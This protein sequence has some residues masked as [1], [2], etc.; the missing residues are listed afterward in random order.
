MKRAFVGKWKKPLLW[1]AGIAV[2]VVVLKLTLLAPPQVKGV[3]PAARDLVA[4][5]YGNGTVEAKV[6]VA[7]APKINGR[8]VALF[9]DQGD[10]VRRGQLLARLDNREFSEQVRQSEAM[11][12]RARATGN[13]EKANLEKARATLA[14]AERNAQRYRSLAEKNLVSRQEAEQYETAC[15]VAR[16]EVARAVA[17]VEAACQETATGSAGKEVARSRLADTEIYAPQDGIIVSRDLEHGAVAA[18]GQSIF[19]MADPATVW[20]KANVDESLLAGIGVG[21]PAQ[22][23]LRSAQQVAIPGHVARLARQS[24]RVTEELEVDVAFDKP[25]KDFRIGEQADVY[26]TAAAKRGVLA[27]PS[28]AVVSRGAQRGV[29]VVVDGRLAFRPVE[30]GIEERNGF[31]EIRKGLAATD[32]VA[33]APPEAMARFRDGKRVRVGS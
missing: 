11:V 14:L 31:S 15:L 10:T 21:K 30:I 22:I 4:E 12:Q 25:R 5:V 23:S 28:A 7:V 16:E 8:I 24:D 32:L 19:T 3:R 17:A 29:W 13:L 1:T 2:A 6:M 33:V 27:L 9:A 20:V 26:I 18:S